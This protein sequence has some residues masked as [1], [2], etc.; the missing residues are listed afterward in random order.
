MN[1]GDAHDDQLTALV[2]AARGDVPPAWFQLGQALVARQRMAEAYG[3]YRR[4][5]LAGFVPA[6]IEGARMRLHGVGCE[7]DIDESV[8]WLRRAEQGGHPVA[9]YLLATVA[10]G[11]VAGVDDDRANQRLFA[12]V[13]ADFPPAGSRDAGGTPRPGGSAAR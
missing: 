8:A 1:A 9:G 7:P 12:A 5:A 6:L 11:G 10:A 13:Q 2:D 3:W 4:A